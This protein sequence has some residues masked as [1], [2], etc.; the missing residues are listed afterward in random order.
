MKQPMVS[1]TIFVDFSGASGTMITILSIVPVILAP[2]NAQTCHD[3]T[4]KVTEK[5]N[6]AKAAGAN[7]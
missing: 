1:D 5:R 7:Y 2:A 6:T 4:A 3:T